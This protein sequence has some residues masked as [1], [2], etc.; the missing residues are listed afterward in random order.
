MCK[1]LSAEEWPLSSAASEVKFICSASSSEF[2][3]SG[4]LVV[5]GKSWDG[6]TVSAAL[7]APSGKLWDGSGGS[8]F[9]AA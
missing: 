4:L 3:F 6:S 9:L 2:E 8:A 5:S 1:S 7:S